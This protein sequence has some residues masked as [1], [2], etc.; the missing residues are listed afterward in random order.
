MKKSLTNKK[1]EANKFELIF[2]IIFLVPNIN[3]GKILWISSSN[4]KD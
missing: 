4:T 2:Y 1:H 3:I